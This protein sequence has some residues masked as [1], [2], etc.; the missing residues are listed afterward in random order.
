MERKQ[1][2]L[3]CHMGVEF[4]VKWLKDI[5]AGSLMQIIE[6]DADIDKDA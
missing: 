4:Q 6:L 1:N 5:G 3:T 2:I